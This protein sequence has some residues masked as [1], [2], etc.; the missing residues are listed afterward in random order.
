AVEGLNEA[1]LS[2][3]AEAKV[4]RCSRIRVDT[5]VVPSNVSY[6]TDSSLVAK[7]AARIGA[8]GRRIRAAGGAVRTK[9]RDRSRA[10]GRR[11]HDLNAKLRTRNAAAKE[12][13]VAVGRGKNAELG[14]LAGAAA[15]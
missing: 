8:T 10:G 3:A 2:K 4:L 11:A 7:A 15:Q 1:L 6:P 9:L 13:G 14:G 12:E 5:T